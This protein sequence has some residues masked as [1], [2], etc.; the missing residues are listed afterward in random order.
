MSFVK[1]H[2]VILRSSIWTLPLHVRIVWITLL[3]LADADG[4]V[5]ASV[6]GL[7]IQAQ[8]TREQCQESI[9]L[10]LGPD[11]DSR[12]GT[13]GERI[14]KVPGGWLVLNHG[15]Y[16]ERQTRAQVLAADRARKHRAKKREALSVTLRD[17][18]HDLSPS[19]AEAEA[20]KKVRTRR[21][22]PAI[23]LSLFDLFWDAYDKKRSK[24][25]TLKAWKKIQPDN[26]LAS[27]IISQARVYVAST[28]DKKFRK[29][30]AT[31][32]NQGCWEDEILQPVQEEHLSKRVGK[33]FSGPA[34]QDI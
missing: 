8:V 17:A 28:P 30:P 15:E 12:D 7:S 16:R 2:G 3:T 33:D 24:A 14:E 31:W 21:S 25:N 18:R 5:E 11:D 34:I 1:I 22:A 23:D 26:T 10:F 4:L 20:E 32:L 27:V 6:G 29:D 19:E 9:D 13:T